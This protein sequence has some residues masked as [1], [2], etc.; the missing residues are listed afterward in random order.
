MIQC[1]FRNPDGTRC[2]NE[3]TAAVE[4]LY[5]GKPVRI[6]VCGLHEYEY[7]YFPIDFGRKLLK[8]L[9]IGASHEH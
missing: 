3:S 2:E 5:R 1:V 9:Q 4:I 8:G 6:R 7:N